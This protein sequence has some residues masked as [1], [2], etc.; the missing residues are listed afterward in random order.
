MCQHLCRV[1]MQRTHV[2]SVTVATC[3]LS[4]AAFCTT[5]AAAA[6][7]SGFVVLAGML[8]DRGA[9]PLGPPCGKITSSWSKC[10]LGLSQH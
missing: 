7:A 6:L 4:V 2:H 1:D 3:G 10:R 8:L 9:G 5:S